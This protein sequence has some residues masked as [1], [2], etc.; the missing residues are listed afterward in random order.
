MTG[1]LARPS[2]DRL[3]TE[4]DTATIQLS[5]E[6]CLHLY[7]TIEQDYDIGSFMKYQI[8]GTTIGWK[9]Y[10]S[11][12]C[13]VSGRQEGTLSLSNH[14]TGIGDRCMSNQDTMVDS[15]TFDDTSLLDTS[16]STWKQ[17][18]KMLHSEKL[19]CP[20]FLIYAIESEG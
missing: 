17:S 18:I 4:S 16:S 11:C 3:T 6:D 5:M 20:L 15:C 13:Q 7:G 8:E 19:S 9:Q 14:E 12:A 2:S 10:D 1:T